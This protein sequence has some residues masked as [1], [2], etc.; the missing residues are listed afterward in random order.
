LISVDQSKGIRRFLPFFVLFVAIVVLFFILSSYTGFFRGYG[1]LGIVLFLFLYFMG[2]PLYR[3][4]TDQ[5][6]IHLLVLEIYVFSAFLIQLFFPSSPFVYLFY[7]IPIFS[8]ALSFGLMGTMLT[9]S[10]IFSLELMRFF[11]TFARP[12]YDFGIVMEKTL[13]LF[14]LALILGF[15]VELKNRIQNRLLHR[16][17][18]LN[19]FRNL[20]GVLDENTE[21]VPF[22]RP[23]LERVTDLTDVPGA[24]LKDA[25][26]SVVRSYLPGDGGA[27]AGNSDEG[28]PQSN[29]RLELEWQGEY[30]ELILLES[31]STGVLREAEEQMVEA[32]GGYVRHLLDRQRLEVELSRENR[33]RQAIFEAVPAGIVIVDGEGRVVDANPAAESMVGETPVGRSVR[34]LFFLNEE[35]ID[36]ETTRFEATL[37][38]DRETVP[39][40][41][42]I[43]RIRHRTESGPRWIIVFTDIS[44]MKELERK[45]ARKRRLVA[46]GELG[47]GLAHEIRNPLGSLSGFVSILEDR[48]EEDHPAKRIVEKIRSSYRRV[49]ELVSQFV[50][51]AREPG[52]V[53]EQF[54]LTTLVR[55]T[56]D[57]INLPDTVSLSVEQPEGTS[58]RVSGD[59]NR[60]KLV[61]RNLIR[62]ARDAIGQ[63]GAIDVALEVRDS[64]ASVSVSDTGDGIEESKQ[65]KI[66]DP[67]VSYSEEGLGLGLSTAH[68]I[69]TDE[70][71]G[72][73]DVESTVGEGTTVSLAIPLEPGDDTKEV[74]DHE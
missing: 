62:N 48:I 36:L 21:S 57:T 30:Y 15:T 65:D 38:T 47:A 56:L 73:I 58:I 50:Q 33:Y 54:D 6:E 16:L 61:L 5:W 1:W 41:L 43:E 52:P 51:Y 71:S 11:L 39:V 25:D 28:D 7:M 8:S 63:S 72:D 18:R 14:I 12:E 42:A 23:F 44:Q 68:R 64:M 55:D 45:A 20:K 26:G 69:I 10:A 29:H 53:K 22:D 19:V 66:F 35:P 4:K 31:G 74:T 9:T 13:P 17:S 67:F 46:L 37:R 60:L 24:L 70:F 32:L 3:F 59:P 34:D 27:S 2:E 49:D 40:D